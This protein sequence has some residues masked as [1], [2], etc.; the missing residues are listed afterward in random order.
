MVNTNVQG[1]IIT[2]TSSIT[3]LFKQIY[4]YPVVS[5]NPAHGYVYLIQYYVI[6][7]VLDLQKVGCFLQ[8]PSPIKIIQRQLGLNNILLKMALKHIFYHNYCSF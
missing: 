2:I 5:L 8:F 7:F 6:K 3:Y 1:N 4:I